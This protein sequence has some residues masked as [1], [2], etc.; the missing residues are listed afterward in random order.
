M[1][2]STRQAEALDVQ[3]EL[4]NLADQVGLDELCEIAAKFITSFGKAAVPSGK[5]ML[6][7]EEWENAERVISREYQ[8]KAFAHAVSTR[9]GA[10]F[11]LLK[12]FGLGEEPSRIIKGLITNFGRLVQL[13]AL[14]EELRET[15]GR[16]DDAK[17]R[18]A[19]QELKI[20]LLSK[21]IG[22]SK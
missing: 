16:P 18:K 12:T 11:E 7:R 21:M 8:D 20:E 9:G 19:L 3:G 14:D 2:R 10:I 15:L 4:S 5:V 13:G 6:D 17:H 1:T 22:A